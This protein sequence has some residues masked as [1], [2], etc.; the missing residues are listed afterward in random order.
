M[1]FCDV[2]ISFLKREVFKKIDKNAI[3]DFLSRIISQKDLIFSN[4]VV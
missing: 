3:L 1:I 2:K 4:N